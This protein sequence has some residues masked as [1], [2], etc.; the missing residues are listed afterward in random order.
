MRSFTA[1]A[2][3]VSDISVDLLA[4][5]Y[6]RCDLALAASRPPSKGTI[7]RVVTAID[8]AQADAAIG[9]WLLHRAS[10]PST[11]SGDNPAEYASPGLR[12]LALDG[13]TLR[14]A[15]DSEGNQVH[16]LAAMT[17]TALVAGQVE[18]GAKTNEIP[19]LSELLDDLDINATVI[20]ADALHTQRD[21]AEYLHQRGAEFCSCVNENQPKL[22]TT[23]DALPWTDV[24][25]AHT[26]TDRGHGRLERRMSSR[27]LSSSVTS[28][29]SRETPNP[30]SLSSA[31]PA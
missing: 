17:H 26:R 21:T 1:I 6:A 16:L 23:L 25:I 15:K 14:G 28:A 3:W 8:P 5:L 27:S 19:M 20:T 13:K 22:F 10:R 4:G 12:E 9:T 18:V 30:R 29:T 11:P 31:S 2:S 7:W 24:P